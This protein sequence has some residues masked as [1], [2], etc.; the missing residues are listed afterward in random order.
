MAGEFCEIIPTVN[1][2]K[3]V[4]YQDIY[5]FTGKNRALTNML[6]AVA[7]TD[8][9][10]NLFTRSD[11][12]NQGEIKFKSLH[13]K[14][15][16]DSQLTALQ[17]VNNERVA[18]GATD[19]S[20]NPIAYD[21]PNAIKDIVLQY[22]DTHE[23][24]HA[25]IKYAGGKY[26]IDLDVTDAS[27][28]KS[29]V[30]IQELDAKFGAMQSYL[31]S[32]GIDPIWSQETSNVVANFRNYRT[33][34]NII[35]SFVGGRSGITNMSKLKSQV[36]LE[37]MLGSPTYRTLAERIIN[38]FGD[39]AA[40]VLA[41][42]S[43]GVPL[44]VANATYWAPVFRSLLN[45]AINVF[46][47]FD[48]NDLIAA[49]DAA[50]QG[51]PQSTETILGA[52]VLDI[53]DVMNDLD[54]RFHIRQDFLEGVGKRVDSLSQAANKFMITALR[55]RELLRRKNGHDKKA[56]RQIKN[57]TKAIEMNQRKIDAGD[58]VSSVSSFLSR[59]YHDFESLQKE[60][61]GIKIEVKAKT[62]EIEKMNEWA[63]AI[64]QAIAM[65]DAYSYVVSQLQ[66][67]RNLDVDQEDVPDNI[68]KDI[69]ATSTGLTKI[70]NNVRDMAR[71]S[72]FEITC[73]FLQKFWGPSDTKVIDGRTVSLSQV[74]D[75]LRHDVNLVEK[76]FLSMNESTDEALGLFYEAVKTN[77]RQRDAE[78]RT[79]DFL[80]RVATD[81]L[82]KAGG[83]SSNV[84]VFKD[85][86]PQLY[87][88]SEVDWLKYNE[89]KEAKKKELYE[90]GVRGDALVEKMREWEDENTEK[91]FP[92]TGQ[93]LEDFRKYMREYVAEV[94]HTDPENV[95]P[96]DYIQKIDMPKAS[97]YGIDNPQD[98]DMDAA[99][100]EYYLRMLALRN[101]ASN[102]IPFAEND[103]FKTI[104][105][106]GDMQELLART[107][108]DP[109]KVLHTIA[110][111]FA[112]LY[113]IRE[114][115]TD[116]GDDFNDL[117][118]GNN[119]RAV[120]STLDGKQ[121]MQLPLFFTHA[122]RDQS[123]VT[124]DMSKAMMAY[125]TSA[126]NYVQMS[127]MIDVLTLAQDYLTTQR[128][129]NESSGGFSL[130][131]ILGR[132]KSQQTSPIEGDISKSGSANWLNNWALSN[133]YNQRKN[134]T[135]ELILFGNPV[136]AGKA[137][138]TI[139]GLTSIFGLTTNF[140]GAEANLLVGEIQMFIESQA[141]EFFLFKNWIA[142]D[143]K[144][145]ILLPAYLMEVSSNNKK[146]M[147][148]LLGDRFNVMEDYYESLKA[149]GFKTSMIGK[150]FDNAELMF[151]YGAGEHLLHNQTMLAILDSVKVWDTQT[152]SETPLYDI[153]SVREDG[154]NG[155]L[156]ENRER[157]KW[158]VRDE[159]GNMTSTREITDEDIDGVE[160]QITYCNKTMHGAFAGIDKGMIHRYAFG[161]LLMNFRQ[162]MPAHYARRFN[163]THYDADLGQYR[164]GY[165]VSAFNFVYNAALGFVKNRTAIAAS[166]DAL[167]DM[168]RANIKRAIAE[169]ETLV[170]LS[171]SLLGLGDYKDKK[172][173]WAYRNL[174]YQIK[175][176]L[177]EVKAS[178]PIDPFAFIDNIITMLNSPFA[179]LNT[180]EK[181]RDTL[182][183]LDMLD[184]IEGGKYDGEN[185]WVHNLKKNAPFIGQISKQIALRDNDDL[186]KVFENHF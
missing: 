155:I 123:R 113:T 174:M 100:R 35:T 79:Y 82:Y 180:I 112:D 169:V 175:R 109:M 49:E 145:S 164:R 69:E 168:D 2:R 57:L 63:Q 90:S 105:F 20:G 118:A 136:S 64:N 73:M 173:N 98:L 150:F 25:K 42:A 138:D 32:I 84:Y 126:V 89:A 15:N 102:G 47:A 13:D 160:K 179:A 56:M 133:L 130:M 14:L 16:L 51:L 158:I 152:D 22:N 44:Q 37:I 95:N 40:Q 129:Y 65:V 151:L 81:K 86:V 39:Q 60:I 80:V 131:S 186:F 115:D 18:I 108:G 143:A 154:A 119:I 6:Y 101:L 27:N 21:N 121:L 38:Q 1:R 128:N 62:E 120:A 59:V 153:F 167:S 132:G 161:R 4:L 11:F 148:A 96:D 23:D 50:V 52:S 78:L 170:V 178:S 71:K 149:N 10:K 33:L 146:S 17:N 156:E 66:N 172:G 106:T 29:N 74:V 122:L 31:H 166:W 157:Y 147:L 54:Q 93:N 41:D 182:N 140:L 111:E 34:R 91:V 53:D 58:Y 94:N 7:Q 72:Q 177:M 185:R 125:L 137:V 114:D 116:F 75:T 46:R 184:H 110:G 68:L 48:V 19:R 134:R 8:S 142:G 67:A 163:K 135:G 176:M 183:V 26:Y 55:Q 162:W 165:Y 70:I 85:G 141:K 124:T 76:L 3:S 99:T 104:Q 97:I 83:R 117:L 36:L 181:L 103:L 5:N 61:D 171:V 30:I 127:D 88:K 12:N 28:Y 43:T 139:T 144:Y 87:M 159:Q 9:V 107:G 77:N 92:F 45:G 24:Y